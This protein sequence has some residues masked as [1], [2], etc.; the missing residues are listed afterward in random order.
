MGGMLQLARL[1]MWDWICAAGSDLP[2]IS[3]LDIRVGHIVSAEKVAKLANHLLVWCGV[4]ICVMRELSI[5]FVWCVKDLFVRCEPSICAI[6]VLS[7]SEVPMRFI[8]ASWSRQPLCGEDRCGWRWWAL[9]HIVAQLLMTFVPSSDYYSFFSPPALRTVV[10]GLAK[11]IPLEQ[12]RDRNVVVVCNLKPSKFKG[13][14]LWQL[15]IYRHTRCSKL[16]SFSI[17]LGNT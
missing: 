8:I 10:S 1:I 3:K 2:D 14:C 7:L 17:C 15:N 13:R 9:I 12:L 11:Y 6:C 5:N 16:N 4:S